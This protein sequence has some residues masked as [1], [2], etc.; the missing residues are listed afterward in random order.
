LVLLI[1]IQ[2]EELSEI[3]ASEIISH[4]Q[5]GPYGTENAS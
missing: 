4:P 5:S 2:T 3:L 1:R